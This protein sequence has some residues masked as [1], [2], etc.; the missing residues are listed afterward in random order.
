MYRCI[1]VYMSS[2]KI[3]LKLIKQVTGTFSFVWRIENT[4]KIGK[5]KVEKR[6]T[7][8]VLPPI[9]QRRKK[10]WKCSRF[11][12]YFF[13]FVF[14]FRIRYINRINSNILRASSCF[15]YCFYFVE[16]TIYLVYATRNWVA[17]T[18]VEYITVADYINIYIYV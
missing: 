18:N 9:K 5:R 14:S 10:T 12:I 6:S 7:G 16:N 17:V 8:I 4:A 11:L 2:R 13:L 15:L 3:Q 1:D